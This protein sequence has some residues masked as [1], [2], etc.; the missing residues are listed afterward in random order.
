MWK[1]IFKIDKSQV[2]GDKKNKEQKLSIKKREHI[3][4]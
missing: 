2:G 1:G 4:F 3:R